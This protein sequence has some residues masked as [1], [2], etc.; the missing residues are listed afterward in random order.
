MSLTPMSKDALQSLKNKLDTETRDD[1]I[2]NIITTIY[3][4]AVNSAKT[5]PNTK[6][7]YNISNISP[8][9][10]L[11]FAPITNISTDFYITNMTDILNGL[12][13]LFP[14]CVV[15]HLVYGTGNN[16]I[17]YDVTKVPPNVSLNTAVPNKDFIV[18]D[19]S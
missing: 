14:N 8:M 4:T 13:P 1:N 10:P 15:S 7:E 12:K 3:S 11:K 9:R 17:L 19:W 6:F 18:I 16:N 5:S 2:K